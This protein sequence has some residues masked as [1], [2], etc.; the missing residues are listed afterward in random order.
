M[1]TNSE[2]MP[3]VTE[4]TGAKVFYENDSYQVYRA[5]GGVPVAVGTKLMYMDGYVIINKLTNQQDGE[6]RSYAAAVSTAHQWDAMIGQISHIESGL[7]I[8]PS[9][10]N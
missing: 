5:I 3:A 7:S 1:T 10:R 6:S 4:Y 9:A 8:P 2:A